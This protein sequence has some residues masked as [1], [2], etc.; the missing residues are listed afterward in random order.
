MSSTNTNLTLE[1]LKALEP[2][3]PCRVCT[4]TLW[5]AVIGFFIHGNCRTCHGCISTAQDGFGISEAYI[6]IAQENS[7]NGQTNPTSSATY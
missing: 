1:E 2:F 7:T 6:K 4:Q 3:C 5:Q